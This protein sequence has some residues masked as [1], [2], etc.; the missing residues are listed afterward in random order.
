[1][2]RN[3]DIL[4]HPFSF[5]QLISNI[6]VWENTHKMELSI[7]HISLKEGNLSNKDKFSRILRSKLNWYERILHPHSSKFSTGEQKIQFLMVI[8]GKAISL[9][10]ESLC[11]HVTWSRDFSN[12]NTFH[13]SSYVYVP[14]FPLSFTTIWYV[15]F[16]LV[17]ARVFWRQTFLPFNTAV[18]LIINYT[19]GYVMRRIKVV[20][21]ITYYHAKFVIETT[22]ANERMF[23]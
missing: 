20:F 12:A 10:K 3:Y 5:V 22:I 11:V 4:H 13:R 9:G 1:M 19:H 21:R 8:N 14:F 18:F 7:P 6:E 2:N 17:G 15:V 16:P 23:S